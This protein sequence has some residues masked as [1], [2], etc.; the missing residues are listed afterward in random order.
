M[1]SSIAEN[2]LPVI[3]LVQK[4]NPSSILDIGVGFGKWG[5]LCREYL[6]IWNM[7]IDK[8]DWK[9]FIGGI[10]ICDKYITDHQKYIYNEITIGNACDIL[11]NLGNYNLIIAN[12]VIEHIEKSKAVDL[13]KCMQSKSDYIIISLPLGDNWLGTTPMVTNVNSYEEHISSWDQTQME[14]LGFGLVATTP[15]PR[16]PVG[17]FLWRKK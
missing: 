14:D 11:P 12:D 9:V 3:V 6:D 16:G 17:V 2:I 4:I 8:R 13:I 10:E 7:R 15:Q 5:M 1:P